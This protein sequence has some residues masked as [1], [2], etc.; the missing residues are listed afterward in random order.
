ML[1]VS[2]SNHRPAEKIGRYR[3]GEI[4]GKLPLFE[5][6]SA[7]RE[8]V[9]AL[10]QRRVVGVAVATVLAMIGTL[11]SA[12][13]SYAQ[14][15]KRNRE[16]SV[17]VTP[18]ARA[19]SAV[20][21]T[22]SPPPTGVYTALEPYRLL[23]TRYGTGAP[24]GAVKSDGTLALQVAGE[25]GVPSS[26]ATAVVLNV[27]VTGPTASGDIVVFADGTSRPLASNLNFTHD[28]TV[29][30]LVIVPLG[31]DGKIA[32]TNQSAG[33]VQLIADVEGYFAPASTSYVTSV[34]NSQLLWNSW[35][36]LETGG[37][38][39][40]EYFTR[41]F[42]FSV[43]AI[44]QNVLDHGSVQVFFTPSP[45]Q[46]P[47]QWVPLPYS[48]VGFGGQYTYNV[49]YITS[50]GQVQL[51]LFFAGLNLSAAQQNDLPEASTYVFPTYNF[52]VVVTPAGGG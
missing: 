29:P 10:T 17:N 16:S 6:P 43:P 42:N 49:V 52:K 34:T 19:P 30:N 38:S 24:V 15:I 8:F 14:E 20:P 18:Q 41:Y 11:T 28:Q 4:M 37:G 50:V 7:I 31:S 13:V 26:G 39:F 36:T 25:G 33:T 40:T 44:T 9:A 2:H 46:N 48:F 1:E 45:T 12:A 51:A 27:T 32:L 21:V 22:A 35:Y 3:Q 47:Q 5:I 23:D